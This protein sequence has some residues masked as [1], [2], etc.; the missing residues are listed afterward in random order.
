[1]HE[2][3]EI[4][5]AHVCRVARKCLFLHLLGP[6]RHGVLEFVVDAYAARKPELFRP[7]LRCFFLKQCEPTQLKLS[8]LGTL[9]SQADETNVKEMAD[10]IL[11]KHDFLS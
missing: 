4:I 10:I 2:G 1:M 7:H 5:M 3:R 8:K 11:A 6:P 9:Q